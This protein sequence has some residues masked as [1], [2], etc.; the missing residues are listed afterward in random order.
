VREA[1]RCGLSLKGRALCRSSISHTPAG[2][3][4]TTRSDPKAHLLNVFSRSPWVAEGA[5]ESTP[6]LLNPMSDC[7]ALRSSLLQM[8]SSR[9]RRVLMACGVFGCKAW[10]GFWLCLEL[11]GGQA[12]RLCFVRLKKGGGRGAQV[13]PGL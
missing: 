11:G 6:L 12:D 9:R 4:K 2:Q 1:Y 5:D 3:T 10:R 7:T 8:R 13:R